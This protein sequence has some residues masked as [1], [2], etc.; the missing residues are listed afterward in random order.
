M[1]TQRHGHHAAIALAL[2]ATM[3][4]SP[5]RAQA[6]GA[7]TPTPLADSART[8]VAA[9]SHEFTA[10]VAAE[11]PAQTRRRGIP[12]GGRVVLGALMGVAAGALTGVALLATTGGSDST[13]VILR[14]FALLGA[15]FGTLGGGLSCLP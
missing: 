2:A 11:Q 10:G 1:T 7:A 3:I 6:T 14:G 4:G 9:R 15:G 5:V 13:G 12:C 8:I